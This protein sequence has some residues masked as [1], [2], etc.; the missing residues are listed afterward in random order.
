MVKPLVAA[1]FLAGNL[2]VYHWFARAQVIPPRADFSAFPM[3]V[4]DWQCAQREYMDEKTLRN[5]GASDYLICDYQRADAPGSGVGVYF[6]Y[7]ETQVREEGGGSGENSIHPPAHCLPGSGWDIIAQQIVEVDLPGLPQRPARVNRLVIAK[8]DAR[9]VV[10][11]WYQSQGRVI[12]EDWRKILY[13]SLDRARRQR[14]DGA[15]VRFTGS[16]D[17]KDEEGSDRRI[18]DLAAAL[19]PE[20]PAYVPN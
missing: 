8:G 11:Y 13:L 3:Q 9:Q 20:L 7:H 1:L 16:L 6:G 17:R 15:L 18:L 4:G 19:L 14:T 2:Y 10:Y 5:L 12:A